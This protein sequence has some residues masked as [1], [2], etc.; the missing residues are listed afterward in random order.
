MKLKL[1]LLLTVLIF[2]NSFANHYPLSSESKQ[3]IAIVAAIGGTIGGG[4]GYAMYLD[5]HKHDAITISEDK[6]VWQKIKDFPWAHVLI[7]A[8]LA[9]ATSGL[10]T[11]YFFTPEK[12][13]EW[14][15]NTLMDYD[16]ELG[17]IQASDIQQLKAGRYSTRFPTLRTFNRLEYLKYK[18]QMIRQ[19]L[20]KVLNSGIEP[21]VRAAQACMQKIDSYEKMLS[22]KITALIQDPSYSI[23]LRIDATEKLIQAQA[24]MANAAMTQASAAMIE[25]TRPRPVIIG[26]H[27]RPPFRL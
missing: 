2:Q 12:T 17:N 4:L 22:N 11:Y 20:V 7:P 23:E 26:V 3:R 6:S 9:A 18:L 15:E 24:Q 21:L 8:T 27:H 14:C 16:Y 5:E 25:A 19:Y 13:Q 10:I 1:S